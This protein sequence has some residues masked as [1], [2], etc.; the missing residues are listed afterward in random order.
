MCFFSL[1]ALKPGVGLSTLDMFLPWEWPGNRPILC[2]RQ[3]CER[4]Q[5]FIDSSVGFMMLSPE[6]SFRRMWDELQYNTMDNQSE[7]PA[8]LAQSKQT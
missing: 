7:R 3:L 1:V 8:N 6:S 4:G 5:C 2:F